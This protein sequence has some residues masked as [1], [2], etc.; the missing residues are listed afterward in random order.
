MEELGSE[1]LDDFFQS[2]SN[3]NLQ[4]NKRYFLIADSDLLNW[5]FTFVLLF[6]LAI[7]F[8]IFFLSGDSLW[9]SPMLL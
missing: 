7:K 1:A 4:S 8:G 6:Q 9:S 5:D 2:D 3:V